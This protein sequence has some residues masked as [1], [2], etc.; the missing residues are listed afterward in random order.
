MNA[1]NDEYMRGYRD[2]A[3]A[4]RNATRDAMYLVTMTAIAAMAFGSW[5]WS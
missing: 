4:V 2:G 5:W 1:D 3:T